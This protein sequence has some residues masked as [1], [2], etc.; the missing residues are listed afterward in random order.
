LAKDTERK[1]LPD[2]PYILETSAEKTKITKM[3]LD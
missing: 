3:F 2:K 1:K